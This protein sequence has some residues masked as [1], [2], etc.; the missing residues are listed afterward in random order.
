MMSTAIDRLVRTAIAVVALVAI[1]VSTVGAQTPEAETLFREGKRLA[2]HGDFAGACEKLDASERLEASIGTEL[3]LADCREKLGQLATA[4]A[5]FVKAAAAAKHSDTDGKREAEAR[6]RAAALEPKLV[7]LRVV[8]PDDARVEGLVIKRNEEAIDAALWDQRVPVDPGKYEIV[9]SAPGYDGWTTKIEVE[10]RDKKVEVPVLDKSKKSPK[11][12]DDAE[13]H[14][15]PRPTRAPDADER[16]TP[17]PTGMTGRHQAALMIGIIGVA[18]LG[19]GAGFGL[20]ARSLEKD[21]D[22]LCPDPQCRIVAGVDDNASARSDGKIAN[23]AL[24]VGGAAVI[25]AGVL[26]L[27]GG[28]H[29]PDSVAIVP[30]TGGMAFAFGGRF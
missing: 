5:L 3:N 16:P 1:Q 8:V 4:W 2:K 19:G 21:A 23:I 22:R 9:A 15:K 12:G 13:P 20:Y 7:H 11:E 17:A 6:R 18:A 28:S 29:A 30:Q 14:A 26:W 27:T 24:A 25:T 10:A